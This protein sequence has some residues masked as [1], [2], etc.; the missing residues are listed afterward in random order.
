MFLLLDNS[1]KLT[2]GKEHKKPHFTSHAFNSNLQCEIT[3]KRA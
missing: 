2:S 3:N 1:I